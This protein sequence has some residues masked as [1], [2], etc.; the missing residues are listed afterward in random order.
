[1]HIVGL[2]KDQNGKEY[3]IV[4]NSWEH[5]TTTKDIYTL[6]K[7]LCVIKQLLCCYIKMV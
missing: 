3:Y 4:K 6:Q 2:V 1:M 7:N 5:P